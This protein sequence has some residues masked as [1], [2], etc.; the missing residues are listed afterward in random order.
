MEYSPSV[1]FML[2]HLAQTGNPVT[3]R[4]LVCQPCDMTHSGGFHP[5]SGNITLCAGSFFNK[6][7]METTIVHE[8]VHLYDH[9]KFKTD[10][11]NLRHHACSE[12]RANSLSGDCRYTRELRRGFG[13]FSKQHQACVRRRAVISVAANTACPSPEA[14]E[15]AVNEVWES[16]F[17]DTRPFDEIY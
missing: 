4:N 8:L 12:I 11:Q 6:G 17:A 9:C 15:K 1:T 14:A 3:P 5:D 13:T 2:K 16:C 10:W 7:H